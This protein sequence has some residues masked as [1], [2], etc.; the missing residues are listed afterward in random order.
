MKIL[1]TGGTGFVGFHTARILRNKGHRLEL[2]VRS[3][4]K[5]RRLFPDTEGIRFHQGNLLDRDSV[6]RAMK[7]CAGV[8]HAAADVSLDRRR[9][10]EIFR[11]N[12]D[13]TENV[14][15]TAWQQGLSHIIHV[16]SVVTLFNP[17]R[18]ILT[19]AS[20]PVA[21]G[22]IYE[23]SK[24]AAEKIA[25][26]LIS[27]GCPVRITYPASV[28]GPDD[29]GLSEAN[30]G[31]SRFLSQGMFVTSSG[32]QAVDVRDLG[33]I[34]ARLM[35]Q[36]EQSG[37]IMTGGI[38]LPWRELAG[39]LERISGKRILKIYGPGGLFRAAG[40]TTDLIRRIIP[41]RFPLSTESMEYLSRW[42]VID[43]SLTEK[44]LDFRFRSAEETY[45]DTY[46]WMLTQG[47]LPP[48]K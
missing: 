4:E 47:I 26:D 14:L 32:F 5:A 2:L 27:K 18:R 6:A 9:K 8:I 17:D 1:I 20:K 42:C 28:I 19:P 40:R 24:Q 22:G 36:P 11:V 10:E 13:G 45:R 35:E 37:F 3:T 44:D 16:S 38:Y 41:V 21:T 31:V 30:M 33:E 43:N 23:E 39:M 46:R 34:H 29:P 7:G 12:R 15:R 25:R 48:G